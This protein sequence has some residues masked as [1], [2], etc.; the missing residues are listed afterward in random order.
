MY[1]DLESD[2][3]RELRKQLFANGKINDEEE[4]ATGD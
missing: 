2:N 4:D 3:Y 1:R